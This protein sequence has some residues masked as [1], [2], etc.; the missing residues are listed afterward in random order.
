MTCT[1]EV[2]TA[3]I[4]CCAEHHAYYLG[5]R[6]LAGVTSVIKDVLPPSYGGVSEDTL[7]NARDRGEQVD[8]LI[9]AYVMGK[10]TE[11]PVGTRYDAKE[12]F[13]KFQNWWDQ[14]RFKDVA[15]QVV[16]HDD[17]IAG[18]IDVRADGTIFDAKC[19]WN[20]LPSHRIQV[21]GYLELGRSGRGVL[22]HL[23]KRYKMPK[24]SEMTEGDCIDWRTVR[25]FW[26]LKRRLAAGR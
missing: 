6:R 4:Q 13:E 14:Q 21:A 20:L 23:T 5:G 7:E 9:A 19:T 8:A 11:Y 15:A 10:L 1:C 12:L 24:L 17:E 22:I 25:N 3:E 2:I 26:S 16:V 18:A